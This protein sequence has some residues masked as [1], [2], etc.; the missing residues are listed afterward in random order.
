M[1][2]GVC[3][4]PDGWCWVWIAHTL[5]PTDSVRFAETMQLMALIRWEEIAGMVP[6]LPAAFPLPTA[7]GSLTPVQLRLLKQGEGRGNRENST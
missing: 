4:L 7:I 5:T 6:V 2:H 1:S 3:Q